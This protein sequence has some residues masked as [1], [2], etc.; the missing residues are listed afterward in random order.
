MG[1]QKTKMSQNFTKIMNILFISFFLMTSF[2]STTKI[3]RQ[4]KQMNDNG[5]RN[6]N[7]MPERKTRLQRL[8]Q[9]FNE[10]RNRMPV[11]GEEPSLEDLVKKAQQRRTQERQEI[12]KRVNSTVQ[13]YRERRAEVQNVIPEIK[14]RINKTRQKSKKLK[15]NSTM[16]FKI[17]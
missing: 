14:S 16:Q 8:A 2:S 9:K 15:V 13:N 7:P 10:N 6:S 11:S 4:Q 5:N 17:E 3:T 1:V 12:A